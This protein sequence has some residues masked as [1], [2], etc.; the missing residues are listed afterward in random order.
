MIANAALVITS[1]HADA[2]WGM[3]GL[4]TAILVA[5]IV[6]VVTVILALG[7]FAAADAAGVD[8]LVPAPGPIPQPSAGLDR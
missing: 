7:V 6:I 4:A 5:E 2:R 8:L 1:R 3:R